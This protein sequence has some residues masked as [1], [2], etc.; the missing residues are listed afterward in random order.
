MTVT[1]KEVKQKTVTD[2]EIEQEI[3]KLR[4]L[5]KKAFGLNHRRFDFYDYLEAAHELH[6]KWKK[7][8]QRSARSKL[9]AYLSLPSEAIGSLSTLLSMLRH[10]KIQRRRTGG[11]RR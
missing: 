7:K 2:K 1:K 4:R 5:E 11:F 10:E 9:S 6:C 3:E 8:S